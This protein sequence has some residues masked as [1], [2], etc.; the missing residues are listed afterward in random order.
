MRLIPLDFQA[1]GK[2]FLMLALIFLCPLA[3]LAFYPAESRYWLAFFLPA[4]GAAALGGLA[5][6]ARPGAQL[7]WKR[8]WQQAS[9]TVLLVWLLGVLFSALPLALGQPLSFCQALFESVSAWTTTGLSVLDVS[10]TPYIYLFYRSFLQFCGGLGFILMMLVLLSNGESMPLFSSEGHPDKLLPA[11]GRSAR[12][13]FSIYTGFLVVGTVAYC[14]VGMPLFDSICHAMCSLST[15]GFSTKLNSIGEYHSLAIELV[16]IVLMLLGTTNFAVLLLL[17][18]GQIKKFCRVSEMRF[19]FLLLVLSIPPVA[20]SLHQG[21]RMPWGES[22]E[23]S[24]FDVI[25]ALSTTGYSSMAYTDWP[26][27][28]LALLILLMLIGGGIGSTAGGMKLSR[29]YQAFRSLGYYLRKQQFFHRQVEDVYYYSSQGR[30]R[31]SPADMVQNF[32]FLGLYL[33]TF[34]AGS[35]LILL[36]NPCSIAE[37]MFEFASSLGTVGLSIGITGPLTNTPTLIV[38]IFGMLLGRLEIVIVFL[39]FRNLFSLFRKRAR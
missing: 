12:L 36:F 6:L 15:G 22:V 21:L 33:L 35:L 25:S 32:A 17:V 16:T 19:L 39:G 11:I 8:R 31:L 37:A 29:V 24:A 27:F 10:K 13:I 7:T 14:V 2:V 4:L 5:L 23:R 20:L 9:V 28:A 34:A 1:L 18:R 30:S 3:V 38:E 26:P